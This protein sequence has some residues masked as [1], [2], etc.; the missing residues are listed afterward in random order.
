M[1]LEAA[2]MKEYDEIILKSKFEAKN[3]LKK[4]EKKLLKILI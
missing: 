2:K 4:Q 1:E 3:I